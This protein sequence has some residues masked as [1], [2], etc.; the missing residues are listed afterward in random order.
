SRGQ[1]PENPLPRLF[2]H[3]SSPIW[4]LAVRSNTAQD[5]QDESLSS[6]Y[7]QWAA[8]GAY[9]EVQAMRFVLGNVVF[10]L[11]AAAL[12]WTRRRTRELS[13]EQT[14]LSLMSPVFEMP[15][16]AAPIFSLLPTPWFF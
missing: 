1:A 5:L 16:A 14:G 6:F 15:I 12:F 11:L 8:L 3:D 7:T 2:L 13:A 10:I 9:A 4:N